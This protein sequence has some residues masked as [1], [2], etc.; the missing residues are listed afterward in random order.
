MVPLVLGALPLLVDEEATGSGQRGHE[1]DVAAARARPA[2]H[3]VAGQDRAELR[4]GPGTGVEDPGDDG[5]RDIRAFCGFAHRA[6]REY[7]VTRR[8]KRWL[9]SLCNAPTFGFW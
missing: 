1:V 8:A 9:T 4:L 7:L 6:L 2:D 3:D 5:Q